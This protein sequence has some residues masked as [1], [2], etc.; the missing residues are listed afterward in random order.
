MTWHR[1]A[2]F[3]GAG[4]ISELTYLTVTVRLPWV[5]YGGQL[6]SWSELLGK[7]WRVFAACLG[8]ILLLMA[9][10]LLGWRLVRQAPRRRLVW[11]F[12]SLYAATLFWL[13]PIT[14]DL[15]T[16]LIRAHLFTDMGLNP[17]LVAPFDV[18]RDPLVLAYPAA[19]DSEPSVY[20][21][22]WLLVSAP[23]TLGLDDLAA[24]TL[25]LKGLALAAFLSC[26]WLVEHILRRIR[27]AQAIEGLYLFAWNPLVLLMAV[28][29]GHND[30]V[31]MAA[32][33]LALW[34]AL[35][36]RWLLAFAVL[37]LS[38]W[39]KYVSVLLFPLLA[40]YAW[41]QL[42]ARRGA[43]GDRLVEGS[44]S[45]GTAEGAQE[46]RR[47]S[48][49]ST[50]PKAVSHGRRLPVVA[51][52]MAVASVV[53]VVLFV[54]FWSPNLV[55]ELVD[56]LLQ[57][58]NWHQAATG[59]PVGMLNAGLVL[60]AAAYV[61][62]VRWSARGAGSFQRL[63]NAGVVALL[64]V[65]VL[66]AARS[67]PWHLIWTAALAPLSDKKWVWTV[68]IGLTAVMLAAQV[69]VEWG[70]PGATIFFQGG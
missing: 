42:G 51:E 15:F 27:P 26:A 24:G 55:S 60:L 49:R 45:H 62:L 21:P 33:L 6:W 36:E 34:F 52:G 8:G 18:G 9:A 47:E 2:L 19:Y 10:Y 37:A 11:V 44:L 32:V 23:G 4:L 35:R 29:D 53:S 14:S 61:L 1:G 5:R 57:P 30:I 56:R 63:A 17:L 54:P 48:L 39:T 20:G 66:V 41:K 43:K 12:V 16:Y 38:V 7:D 70:T 46:D 3:L 65:F 58:D 64:S 50:A 25:Y 68:L 69:W 40:I 67:Q 31:M 28:G 59:L 22:A 13:L